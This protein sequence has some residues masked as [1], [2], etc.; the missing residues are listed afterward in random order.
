MRHA[1]KEGILGLVGPLQ[2]LLCTV[3]SSMRRRNATSSPTHTAPTTRP[4]ESRL[5]STETCRWIGLLWSLECSSRSKH[6]HGVPL[7]ACR[8]TASTEELASAWPQGAQHEAA[9]EGLCMCE[10]AAEVAAEVVA[11]VAAGGG[12]D[13]GGGDGGGGGGGRLGCG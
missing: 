10:V 8:R 13:G 3:A 1:G 12:G 9:L 4:D 6:G 7:M 11:E 2:L 5:G